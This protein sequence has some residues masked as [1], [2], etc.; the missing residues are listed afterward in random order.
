[1]RVSSCN[2]FPAQL[3]AKE[4]SYL[5]HHAQLIWRTNMVPCLLLTILALLQVKKFIDVYDNDHYNASVFVPFNED[6]RAAWE[7]AKSSR[8]QISRYA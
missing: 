6:E 8:A 3:H 7:L 2:V 5:L 4:Q 1:M